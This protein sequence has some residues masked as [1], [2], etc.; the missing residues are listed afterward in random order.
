MVMQRGRRAK[1]GVKWEAVMQSGKDR[2]TGPTKQKASC[3]GIMSKQKSGIIR[4][5]QAKV[6]GCGRHVRRVWK[7]QTVHRIEDAE[8][9]SDE[10]EIWTRKDDVCSIASGAVKPLRRKKQRRG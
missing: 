8:A 4:I 6:A 10:Q 5:R 7:Q 1:G 2:N 3:I 9:A